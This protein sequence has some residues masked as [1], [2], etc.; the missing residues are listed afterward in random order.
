MGL[1]RLTRLLT[2]R[3]A[4]AT[5]GDVLA[6]SYNVL[7]GIIV[8]LAILWRPLQG[9][10]QAPP[11]TAPFQLEPLWLV[12]VGAAWIL[13]LFL[14]G[15]SRI[16]PVALNSPQARW[17]L[18]SMESRTRLLWP[19]LLVRWL[20][21]AGIGALLGLVIALGLGAPAAVTIVAFACV[22]FTFVN[23][24]VLVQPRR[25]ESRWTDALVAIVPLIGA[26]VAI[27]GAPAPRADGRGMAA[28]LAISVLGAI[29][30]GV[31]AW[32]ALPRIHD[33]DIARSARTA[34]ELSSALLQLNTRELSRAFERAP[35]R[36]GRRSGQFRWVRGPVRAIAAADAT[37]LARSPRHLAQI[38]VGIAVAIISVSLTAYSPLVALLA[39]AVGGY[40]A[41][42]AS[43]EGA[44]A[45]HRTP[46]L[47]T[48]LPLSSRSVRAAR[49]IV[50][51]T[52]MLVVGSGLSVLVGL[53]VGEPLGFAL[54]G[55]AG[56]LTWAAAVLR[57]AYRAERQLSGA[58]VPTPMGAFPADAFQ[59]FA[60]GADLAMLLL[61]PTWIAIL[62]STATWQLALA[63]AVCSLLAAWWVIHAAK[64]RAIS[65]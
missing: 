9:A 43:A 24:L 19:V 39:V 57:A 25:S 50:P 29:A 36:P 32:S 3:N 7:L 45:A 60:T 13:A 27:A 34:G 31:G 8:A 48:L 55:V 52:V 23:V 58:V 21:A 17:W 26:L 40:L 56:A 47:D 28:L 46:S 4:T 49:L 5:W 18:P 33:G 54:L 16:G 14:A 2:H 51:S 6:D 61:L 41:A 64:A 22:S 65:V 20:L 38:A 44:R 53:R 30:S 62:I 59:V 35:K 1:R 15:M 42:L 37:R 11:S 10:S 12:M 63:Q